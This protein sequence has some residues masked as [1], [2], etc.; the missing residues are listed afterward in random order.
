M[1][2][3]WEGDQVAG[4]SGSVVCVIGLLVLVFV[5][6]GRCC[7]G[8]FASHELRIWGLDLG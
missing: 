7:G 2:C 1:G 4:G 6:V 3:R 5:V 8:R